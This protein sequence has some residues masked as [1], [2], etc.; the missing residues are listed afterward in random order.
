MTFIHLA[1]TRNGQTQQINRA[2][3]T[4][5]ADLKCKAVQAPDCDDPST[6]SHKQLVSL[7]L[8]LQNQLADALALLEEG[9]TAAYSDAS[10]T[11]TTAYW[12]SKHVADESGVAVCTICR[13]AKELGGTKLAGDWLFPV[14]TTY[15]RRRKSK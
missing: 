13:N 3:K 5:A 14:G 8:S 7:V 15:G 12:D 1:A 4:M 2:Y 10:V 9:R 11:G 6:L